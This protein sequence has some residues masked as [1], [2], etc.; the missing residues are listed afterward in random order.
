MTITA[1]QLERELLIH[2]IT[3]SDAGCLDAIPDDIADMVKLGIIDE[4][5][6]GE[7]TVDLD[8]EQQRR[9]KAIWDEH[10]EELQAA[11]RKQ[12]EDIKTDVPHEAEVEPDL[13]HIE[14]DELIR[15]AENSTQGAQ[16]KKL[17]AG[18]WDGLE[19]TSE[20]EARLG[21]LE[22]IAWYADSR[23]QVMRVFNKS[24]QWV[25]AVESGE[26][27]RLA[28]EEVAAA[29]SAANGHGHYQP[30]EEPK[31]VTQ[32]QINDR[33]LHEMADET[34][35]AMI[36]V[37]NPPKIFVR[38]NV[39][40]RVIRSDPNMP[41]LEVMTPA[42]LEDRESRAAD[43]V[44][45]KRTKNGLMVTLMSPPPRIAANIMA[46]GTWDF[47]MIQGV[48]PFPIIHNDGSIST[49]PG[50]DPQSEYF[51]DG[52][53]DV[54]LIEKPTQQDAKD[55][56]KYILDEVF[57]DFPFAEEAS[58]TH[59]LVGLLSILV[60]P[61]L[62]GRTPLILINKPTA[63]TGASLYMDLISLISSGMPCPMSTPPED[64]KEFKKSLTAHILKGEQIICYDNIEI[65]FH[66]PALSSALTTEHYTDRILGVSQT[67][68]II[69]HTCVYATGNGVTLGG[70]Y[71]RRTILIDLDAA[72][73]RP[74]ER[75]GFKHPLLKSWVIDNRGDLL[76]KALTIIR[77]WI[78]AGKPDGA[79][80]GKETIGSFEE[81]FAMMDGILTFAGL[82]HFHENWEKLYGY[83][84][85]ESDDCGAI[86]H[87]AYP[88][89]TYDGT[90]TG[91]PWS[92]TTKEFMHVIETSIAL[93]AAE[94]AKAIAE[95]KTEAK[96]AFDTPVHPHA[97]LDLAPDDLREAIEKKS[98]K[99]VGKFL[100]KMKGKRFEVESDLKPG[101]K[102][103]DYMIYQDRGSTSKQKVNRSKWKI[104]MAERGKKYKESESHDA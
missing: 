72:I 88:Y 40:V 14:D 8:D 44:L 66:S 103:M 79:L 50:Y 6:A 42:M 22:M 43:F 101:E 56:A 4:H 65:D 37:N 41:A 74:A 80:K 90:R 82:E 86:L 51:Y 36:A 75:T 46:R 58:K 98:T 60:R 99:S 91:H 84:N 5:V 20:P 96:T 2:D 11:R 78:L 27:T 102:R 13:P 12:L 77:A 92:F 24:K 93:C 100:Q 67:I 30:P 31:P 9:A 87:A 48:T 45:V 32:I 73:P 49:T 55:A 28:D 17:M 15:A 52:S 54:K 89:C 19:Y 7:L 29:I 85:E 63:G 25:L 38:G 34:L 68:D 53:V 76:G 1:A 69:H 3:S 64:E 70:D 39:L 81:W 26:W 61:I 62:K 83:V 57:G 21:L 47:P 95:G 71:P 23:L 16:F 10:I 104:V 18:E 59:A 97:L 33:R 94:I 35:A